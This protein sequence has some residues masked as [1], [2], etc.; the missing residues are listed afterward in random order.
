MLNRNDLLNYNGNNGEDVAQASNGRWEVCNR[1]N[2]KS[3]LNVDF[4]QI[5]FLKSIH[6]FMYLDNEENSTTANDHQRIRN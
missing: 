5:V 2:G 3:V 4:R 6:I 1:S